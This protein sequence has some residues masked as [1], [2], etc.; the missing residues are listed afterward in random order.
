MG[1]LQEDWFVQGILPSQTG[2]CRDSA[3][4]VPVLVVAPGAFRS[5]SGK[6]AEVSKVLG[7]SLWHDMGRSVKAEHIN[8]A[9]SK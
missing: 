7:H 1:S 4:T 3:G 9:M 5:L 2:H 6:A 8:Q